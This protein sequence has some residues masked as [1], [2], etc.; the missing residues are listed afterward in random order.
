MDTMM[1]RTAAASAIG[2][3]HARGARNGQDAAVAWIGGDAAV[4]VACDGCSSGASSEVGARLGAKLFARAIGSR[5]AAGAAV[6]RED[7]W[8]AVRADVVHV[9]AGLLE[10]LGERGDAIAE[11]L[12]FTV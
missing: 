4:I 6:D 11:A 10:H 3:R 8:A 9:L 7:T 1:W 12:L 5:L 2:A